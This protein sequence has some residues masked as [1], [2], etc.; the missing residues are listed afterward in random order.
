MEFTWDGLTDAG[1]PASAGAYSVEVKASINNQTQAVDTLV[2]AKVES[3]TLG[4]AG[5][6]MQLNLAGLGPVDTSQVRQLL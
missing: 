3:V 4:K 5:A 1:Q 2:A 6:G